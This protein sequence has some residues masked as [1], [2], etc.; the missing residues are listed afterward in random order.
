VEQDVRQ[1]E[2]ETAGLE[3]CLGRVLLMEVNRHAPLFGHQ[4]SDAKQAGGHIDAVIFRV[5]ESAGDRLRMHADSTTEIEDATR[6][7]RTEAFLQLI[8]QGRCTSIPGRIF[9]TLANGIDR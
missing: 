6:R 7:Q 9:L 1:H 2:I 5:R 4:V 8:Q 3:G